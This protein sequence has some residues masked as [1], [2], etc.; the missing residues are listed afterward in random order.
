MQCAG[1][2]AREVEHVVDESHEPPGLVLDAAEQ[3]V[4]FVLGHA[5]AQGRGR[6]GDRGQRRAQVVGDGLQKGAAQ[7][8]GLLQR[9]Q[10]DALVLEARAPEREAEDAAERLE[11]RD[12]LALGA[13][14]TG[15]GGEVAERDAAVAD[16]QREHA[17]LA[18]Q[19]DDPRAV[20]GVHHLCEQCRCRGIV[21]DALVELLV[22]QRDAQ[23]GTAQAENLAGIG[24]RAPERG[25]QVVAA[26]QIDRERLQQ[27]HAARAPLGGCT[28]R[29]EAA[30]VVG[31]HD[32]DQRVDDE[33][34]NAGRR[35][36]AERVVRLRE[37]EVE[38]QRADQREHERQGASAVR[39]DQR[40]QQQHERERARVEP[41]AQRHEHGD[42]DEQREQRGRAG[43]RAAPRRLVVEFGQAAADGGHRARAQAHAV[44]R[45]PRA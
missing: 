27:L 5:L 39:G 10:H 25:A 8:I 23:R 7:T 12:R 45:T 42:R 20:R 17:A 44:H 6:G 18:A 33:R 1:L 35:L 31:E 11:H 19:R 24:E 3:R 43:Q 16:R 21:A 41:V 30:D 15:V 13:A 29:A 32:R 22:A 38:R 34:G 26:D 28:G 14:V 36:D 9:L 37:E 2:D 40:R 4:A